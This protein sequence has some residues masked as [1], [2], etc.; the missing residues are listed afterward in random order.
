[1]KHQTTKQEGAG[2]E[3]E[4][5]DETATQQVELI[6]HQGEG[7]QPEDVAASEQ[8]TFPMLKCYIVIFGHWGKHLCG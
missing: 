8:S 2:T 6:M 1:M 5:E 4:A 7:S 3:T